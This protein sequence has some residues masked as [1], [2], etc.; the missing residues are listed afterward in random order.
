MFMS[1]WLLNLSLKTEKK[2]FLQ[3]QWTVHVIK[4]IQNIFYNILNDK[5]H[6]RI[7]CKWK[8]NLDGPTPWP[9]FP[10]SGKCYLGKYS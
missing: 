7:S 6:Y 10:N 9:S 2:L 8:D 1:K 4:H 3:K 5:T